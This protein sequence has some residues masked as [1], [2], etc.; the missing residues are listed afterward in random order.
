MIWS[1][2]AREADV[3]T[4]LDGLDL[5]GSSMCRRRFGSCDRRAGPLGNVI[6]LPLLPTAIPMPPTVDAAPT[7]H[8]DPLRRKALLL[9]GGSAE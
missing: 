9:R 8:R 7:G 2:V 3:D 1:E 4:R 5:A 6:Y